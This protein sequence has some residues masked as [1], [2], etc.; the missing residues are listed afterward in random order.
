M[1]QTAWSLQ[2]DS[3]TMHCLCLTL[4]CYNNI[5]LEVENVKMSFYGAPQIKLVTALK[6]NSQMLRGVNNG[7]TFSQ[8][9]LGY[10]IT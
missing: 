5:L 7:D 1:Q 4:D 10:Y 2:I 9:L 6:S 8:S 3:N